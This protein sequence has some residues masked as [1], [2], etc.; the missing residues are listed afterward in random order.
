VDLP[1]AE[2]TTPAPG[3]RNAR[4]EN[5]TEGSTP[6]VDSNFAGLIPAEVAVRWSGEDSRQ[7]PVAASPLSL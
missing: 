4:A 6:D 2:L 1:A 7:D 3:A 5:A